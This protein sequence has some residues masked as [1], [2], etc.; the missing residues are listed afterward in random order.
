M[1]I[2]IPIL[3]IAALF[4]ILIGLLWYGPLFG[5]ICRKKSNLVKERMTGKYLVKIVSVT[6]AAAV[7]IALALMQMVIHQMGVYSTLAGD[8]GFSNST[9][10]AFAYFENFISLYNDRF[11][12]FGHGALHG[13][14]YAICLVIP[15]SAIQALLEN[16][17][18][19]YM[20]INAGY[21]TLT[22]AIMGGI[23][24][25]WL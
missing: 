13:V 22:L 14:L 20:A 2:N 9:G 17:S 1:E 5:N 4:P 21:W 3:F 23:I 6:Y 19:Q 7:L 11:R 25:E 16:K 10:E 12:T 15:I 8:P 24:C 18:L